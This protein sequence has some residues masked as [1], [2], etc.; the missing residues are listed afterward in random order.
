MPLWRLR[1]FAL[2]CYTAAVSIECNLIV[3]LIAAVVD[4]GGG[5]YERFAADL[6]PG[7]VPGGW[8]AALLAVK[9]KK[10]ATEMCCRS[11]AKSRLS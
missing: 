6:C 8:S 5:R 11:T 10:A 1:V 2:L 3:A 7:G 4:T 9:A